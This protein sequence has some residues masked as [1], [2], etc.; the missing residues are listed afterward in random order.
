MSI[1]VADLLFIVGGVVVFLSPL[2][3][4]YLCF[5][6][7]KQHRPLLKKSLIG[8]AGLQLTVL[9]YFGWLFGT[10]VRHVNHMKWI[11]PL[12]FVDVLVWVCFGIGYGLAALR[13]RVKTKVRR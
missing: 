11:A 13:Y 5:G 7:P 4:G 12:V 1:T 8:I 2:L 3:V 9:I 10:S 6:S